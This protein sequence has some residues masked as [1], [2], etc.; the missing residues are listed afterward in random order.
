MTIPLSQL[1]LAFLLLAIGFIAG[2]LVTYLW[3]FREGQ[4]DH[5][6]ENPQPSKKI[7]TDNSAP[8]L[9]DQRIQSVI[10]P[11]PLPTL[12]KKLGQ[13]PALP[14]AVDQPLEVQ[15]KIIE[16]VSIVSQIDEILQEMILKKGMGARGIQ[17]KEDL[18]QGVL[19]WIGLDRF[20]GIDAVPDA[21]VRSM[22][23]EAV[24]VWEQ[25]AAKK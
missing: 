10:A 14:Q 20:V 5:K 22:I 11:P 25:R 6:G 19:V 9:V 1:L 15:K 13:K 7:K 8:S 16:P 3:F 4:K 17:L 24:S 23:R 18:R 12:S 21:E 2:V